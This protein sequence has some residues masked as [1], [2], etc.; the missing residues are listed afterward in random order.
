MFGDNANMVFLDTYRKGNVVGG[1]ER[2]DHTYRVDRPTH[3]RALFLPSSAP[4]ILPYSCP[5][6]CA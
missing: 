1:Y 6:P 3:L 4:R 2:H 5:N